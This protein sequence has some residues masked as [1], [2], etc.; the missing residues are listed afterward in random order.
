LADNAGQR[1]ANPTLVVFYSFLPVISRTKLVS[2]IEFQNV[3][4]GF[5]EKKDGKFFI[6]WSDGVVKRVLQP[7]L[8]LPDQVLLLVATTVPSTSAS[9]LQLWTECKT[10]NHFL[11]TLRRLHKSRLLEFTETTGE[12]QI[13]PPGSQFVME[14]IRTK[15]LHIT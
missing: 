2:L 11:K 5:C 10:T 8:K 4:K 14:L 12:V 7:K 6:I 13:L 1:V 15:N 9:Q 3:S